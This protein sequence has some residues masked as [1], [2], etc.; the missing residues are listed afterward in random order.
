MSSYV[1]AS[2]RFARPQGAT[3]TDEEIEGCNVAALVSAGH[4]VPAEFPAEVPPVK[5]TADQA[6]TPK[7]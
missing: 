1:V 3:V 6:T 7:E 5:P 4:L 2:S